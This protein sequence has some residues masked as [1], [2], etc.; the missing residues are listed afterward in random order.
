[1]EVTRRNFIKEHAGDLQLGGTRGSNIGQ[2]EKP[3]AN[4]AAEKPS[5]SCK[6]ALG[7]GW[8]FRVD[9]S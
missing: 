7:L 3:A 8:L 5:S 9:P 6:G 2:K 4:A 1:M